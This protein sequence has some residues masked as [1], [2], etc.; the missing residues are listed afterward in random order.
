MQKQ[1]ASFLASGGTLVQVTNPDLMRPVIPIQ[2]VSEQDVSATT[3][4]KSSK[5]KSG[6]NPKSRLERVGRKQQ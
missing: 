4:E 1:A 5:K 3:D 6:V 2:L